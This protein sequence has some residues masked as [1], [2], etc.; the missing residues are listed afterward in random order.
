MVEADDRSVRKPLRRNV[1]R[2]NY[3]IVDTRQI[4]WMFFLAIRTWLNMFVFILLYA[5]N[6]CS[7]Y[8]MVVQ[9]LANR[10]QDTYMY[11]TEISDKYVVKQFV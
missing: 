1:D 8:N 9:P 11:M 2:E 6:E 3:N 4:Q 10:T 7:S 5:S